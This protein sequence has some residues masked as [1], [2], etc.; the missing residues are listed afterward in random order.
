MKVKG[1]SIGELD[2]LIKDNKIRDGLTVGTIYETKQ[3]LRL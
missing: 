2:R 3:R 1:F